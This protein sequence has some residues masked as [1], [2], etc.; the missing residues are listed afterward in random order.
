MQDGLSY[1]ISGVSVAFLLLGIR[2]IKQVL[3]VRI[4][5]APAYGSLPLE[6]GFK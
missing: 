4:T 5:P 1:A 6:S 2:L 3:I